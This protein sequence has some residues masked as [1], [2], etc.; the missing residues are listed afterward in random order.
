MHLPSMTQRQE[1]RLII[2]TY[3]CQ[4]NRQIHP[5]RVEHAGKLRQRGVNSRGNHVVFIDLSLFFSCATLLLLS[6]ALPPNTTFES[7]HRQ[8]KLVLFEVPLADQ[9]ILV[10]Q[11]QRLMPKRIRFHW[12]S[13]A[14]ELSTVT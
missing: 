4:W 11:R 8:T 14:A 9:R 13:S 3:A 2:P 7:D 10:Y 12:N 6:S 1:Y 5:G